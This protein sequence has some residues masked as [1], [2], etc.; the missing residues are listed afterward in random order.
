MRAHL[1][2]LAALALGACAPA[3]S[4]AGDAG[5]NRDSASLGAD[6]NQVDVA[7]AGDGATVA[8][9]PERDGVLTFYA[10]T[11]AGACSYPATPGSLLVAAMDAPEWAGSAVCGQCVRVTGPR[12]VVTVRIV[13]LCPECE[14]GHLDLSREAFALV[15]DPVQGRVS[16]RWQPVACE[17]SGNVGYHYKDGSNQ[18]WTA[19]QPRNH[20]RPVRS[21]EAQQGGQW[22]ALQRQDYNYFVGTNLGTGPFT[23]RL[24]ADDGQQLVDTVPFPGAD[25]DV[26]GAGQFR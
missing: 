17:V 6:S 7:P 14:A 9:G 13:D 12:G 5:A 8:L 3:P 10:A 1:L 20:R 18:W 23:L 15:A 26:P 2:P 19:L 25:T 11:G 4:P 21:L 16:A 22:V 24:T